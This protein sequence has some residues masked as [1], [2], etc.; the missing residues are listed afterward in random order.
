MSFSIEDLIQVQ[1]NSGLSNNKIK[2]LATTIR[3]RLGRS[4]VQRNF[5]GELALFGADIKEEYVVQEVRVGQDLIQIAHCQD[6]NDHVTKVLNKR[7]LNPHDTMIKLAIDGGQGFLKVIAFFIGIE[8]ESGARC[9][10]SSLAAAR[11]KDSGAMKAVPLAIAQVSESYE[12]LRIILELIH[13]DSVLFK[14]AADLR[15]CAL[16]L[17]LQSAASCHPC[18]WCNIHKDKYF[19]ASQE[20]VE[21]R[22]FGSIRRQAS[23]FN[24]GGKK[25]AKH[26]F[27]CVNEPLFS[28]PDATEVMDVFPPMELHIFLG[29]TSRIF[30]FLCNEMEQ[31]AIAWLKDLHLEKCVYHGST[32]FNGRACRTLVQNFARLEGLCPYDDS[33]FRAQLFVQ[34]F[35]TLDSVVASCFGNTLSDSYSDDIDVFER[36]YCDLGYPASPKVH[37]LIVHVRQFIE[38]SGKS[39]GIFSEQACETFHSVFQ[40][41]WKTRYARKPHPEYPRKLLECV[42]EVASKHGH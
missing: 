9:S 31:L 28:E 26:F 37:A 34:A 6:F 25:N 24:D 29:V 33:R 18:I 17:G 41:S 32:S 2:K 13:V 36:A 35:R 5:Q 22:T 15:V 1:L 16:L 8:S 39:L 40:N 42:Q 20:D 11:F 30:N 3:Q 21:L 12:S 38:R 7:E 27:N 23:L 10:A 19:H 4:S 14:V